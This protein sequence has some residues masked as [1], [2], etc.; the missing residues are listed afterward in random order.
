MDPLAP[1]GLDASELVVVLRQCDVWG[2]QQPSMVQAVRQGRS[3]ALVVRLLT[4]DGRII[5]KI[6]T[7]ADRLERARREL[8][9]T[10]D[11][12]LTRV[13]AGYVAGEDSHDRVSL[14]TVERDPLPAPDSLTDHEWTSLASALGSLHRTS[15]P[16]GIVLPGPASPPTSSIAA[17]LEIWADRVPVGVAVGAAEIIRNRAEAVGPGTAGQVLEH[18]DCHTENIV[19]DEGGRFR[20]IDWQEARTGDGFSDLVFLWQRAEFAG[21]GPPRE[22]M[23]HAYAAARGL[24]VDQHVRR[25][26][27]GAELRLLVLA[28]PPFLGYGSAASQRH[29]SD[30]LGHLTATLSRD[31]VADVRRQLRGCRTGCPRSDDLRERGRL[32]VLGGRPVGSDTVQVPPPTP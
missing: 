21:A 17:S 11:P 2:L 18:G 20:W 13:T 16:P 8:R 30:R 6:T 31:V 19:R 4:S 15:R 32:D 28:W 22:E 12:G 14:A 26:L 24:V 9:L 3:G 29:L 1:S 7:A 10:A 23:T 25:E 27:D 5:V